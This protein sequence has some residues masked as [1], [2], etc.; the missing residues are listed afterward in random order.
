MTPVFASKQDRAKLAAI[1]TVLRPV[2]GRTS[3]ARPKLVGPDGHQ[4]ELPESVYYLLR[5]VAEVLERGD[6]ITVVQ[7]GRELTTQQAADLLNVSR[8]YLVRLLEED[9]LPHTR[10][11]KHRRLKLEDVLA[12]KA[13]RDQERAK[14]LAA[15]TALTEE[16]GGYDDEL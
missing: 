11:G 5:K 14:G 12:Y 1:S 4:H 10:T 9:R 6:A 15:L 3:R 16:M 13:K 2:Q 7:V 8:Q